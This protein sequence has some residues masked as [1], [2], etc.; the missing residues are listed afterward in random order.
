[1]STAKPMEMGD[2]AR[3]YILAGGRRGFTPRQWR[4]MRHKFNRAEGFYYGHWG[5]ASK[6]HA[7][8]QRPRRE[9]AQ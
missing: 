1:M 5:E 2:R 6:G 3:N 8:P 4:R 7:T 9:V